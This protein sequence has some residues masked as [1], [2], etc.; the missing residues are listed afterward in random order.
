MRSEELQFDTKEVGK[1]RNKSE[2]QVRLGKSGS[3][4]D[5]FSASHCQSTPVAV[6]K[7]KFPSNIQ[8]LSSS[9]TARA[10]FAAFVAEVSFAH[11]LNHPNI[12]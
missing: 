11:S 8:E 5:V 1:G 12:V 10:A 2:I 7:L 9:D 4:G 3:F 6:K